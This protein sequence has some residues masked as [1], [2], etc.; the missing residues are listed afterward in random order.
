MLS[1]G[2][3][4]RLGLIAAT[5]EQAGNGDILVQIIPMDAAGADEEICSLLRCPAQ[6]ARKPD[7]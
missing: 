5:R 7:D 3:F 4:T 1:G 6:Q 2:A